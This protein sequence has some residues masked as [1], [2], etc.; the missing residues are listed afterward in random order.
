MPTWKTSFIRI[1]GGREHLDAAMSLMQ[2]H[3]DVRHRVCGDC[4]EATGPGID[5]GISGHP[6]RVDHVIETI[7][8]LTVSVDPILAPPFRY[9]VRSGTA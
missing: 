9:F 5:L 2:E 4:V 6:N 1:V 7:R 8:L 3:R